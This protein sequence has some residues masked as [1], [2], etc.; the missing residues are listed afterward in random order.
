MDV[1]EAL[2]EW[3]IS[4]FM[5]IPLCLE[6]N[7]RLQVLILLMPLVVLLKVKLYQMNN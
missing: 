3:F 6:I 4:F 5:E 1:K 2:L 7:L